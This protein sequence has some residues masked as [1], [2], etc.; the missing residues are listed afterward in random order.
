M[1]VGSWVERDRIGIWLT[2]NR[3]GK[4]VIEWWDE[5]AAQMFE[6]GFF[7][8]GTIRGQT[9][10]GRDFEESVLDYAEYI[11][12]LEKT[13][14]PYLPQT[15]ER[16][17]VIEVPFKESPAWVREEWQRLHPGSI[18][19][20]RVYR[21]T[22]ARIHSP[23]FEYAV[24]DI[25]AHKAGKTM[26]RYVPPYESLLA[27]TPEERALYFGGAVKLGP[28]EA[29]AVMDFWGD[30][31]KS[32]DLYVHPVAYEPPRLLAPSLTERQM[33]LLATI[34][35][36]IPSY[37]RE[38]FQ[39]HRVSQAE[40]DELQRMGLIDRRGA[41]TVMGRNAAGRTQPLDRYGGASLQTKPIPR[42]IGPA[43]RR[44]APEELEFFADSPDHCCSS[45][46][47]TGLRPQLEEAFRE[48]I[49]RAK[50]RK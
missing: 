39:A 40:L 1:S 45:V 47:G 8:P 9:I 42:L 16:D 43:E 41:I 34:R 12:V 18:P 36:Y 20:V 6:D 2:D 38:V 4:G 28:D 21:T 13:G 23:V 11:G 33:R 35:S 25:V 14:L 22:V 15:M 5:D 19:R 26:A 48:A 7:K 17:E 27:A 31:F 37:R 50:G 44:E 29:I 30:R 46:D 3:T 24:R 32:I 49:S 10:T